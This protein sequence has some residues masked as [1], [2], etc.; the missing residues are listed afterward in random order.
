MTWINET[1]LMHEKFA[2]PVVSK[3]FRR[4]PLYFRNP[5]LVPEKFV[6]LDQIPVPRCL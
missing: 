1:L 4:L 2:E 6:V 3:D 5:S